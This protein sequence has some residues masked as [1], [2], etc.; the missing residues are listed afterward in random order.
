LRKKT[1]AVAAMTQ[2]FA[3]LRKAGIVAQS[4]SCRQVRPYRTDMVVAIRLP[5]F[6][7]FPRFWPH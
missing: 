3:A 6:L 1:A 7:R 5:I 4:M 2:I